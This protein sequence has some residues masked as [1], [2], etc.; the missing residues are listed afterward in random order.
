[1][2]QVHTEDQVENWEAFNAGPHQGNLLHCY[3]IQPWYKGR[4]AAWVINSKRNRNVCTF[5]NGNKSNPNVVLKGKCLFATCPIKIGQELLL[6]YPYS[7]VVER[8]CMVS[9]G[10]KL[11]DPMF[12]VPKVNTNVEVKF[13]RYNVRIATFDRTLRIHRI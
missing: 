1:V 11:P 5:V 2:T 13:D 8:K 6:T 12:R 10:E 3:L 7:P 9:G 4:E